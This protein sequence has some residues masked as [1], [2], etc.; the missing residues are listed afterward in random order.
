M[1]LTKTLKAKWHGNNR[2]WYE[3]KGYIYTK[4]NDEFEV[5][6]EDI[7]PSKLHKYFVEVSCD[8]CDNKE[9]IKTS[10]NKYLNNVKNNDGK[11][12]C[13]NCKR[14]KENSKYINMKVGFIGVGKLGKEAA[15]VMQSAG[16]EVTG[17]D[18]TEIKNTTIDVIKLKQKRLR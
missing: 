2:A 6:L 13:Q 1:L 9:I 15:E 12:V 18:V 16:H 5:R 11:Y 14:E 10:L 4:K 8:D 17:Y 3:S 7:Y